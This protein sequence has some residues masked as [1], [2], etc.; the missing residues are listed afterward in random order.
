MAYE[1]NLKFAKME[2]IDL[3]SLKNEKV[4]LN[5]NNNNIFANTY[6]FVGL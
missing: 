4:V 3:R 2:K 5:N 1:Q 6:H